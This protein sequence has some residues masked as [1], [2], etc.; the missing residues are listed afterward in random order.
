MLARIYPK[1]FLQETVKKLHARAGP[2]QIL[3]KLNHNAYIID[4]SQDFSVNS[5]FNIGDLVD[6][7]G[8]DFNS[9]KSIK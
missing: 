6:Y 1:Q 8:H 3:K 2:F 9:S 7:K 4:L 5:T